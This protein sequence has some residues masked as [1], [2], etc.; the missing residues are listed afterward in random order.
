VKGKREQQRAEL[1]AAA[2]LAIDKAL[3][4]DERAGAP[5]LTE[6]EDVI[7]KLRKEFGQR[8][9]EVLLEGQEAKKPVPGPEC[10]TCQREM[11]YKGAKKTGV[12]T[13]LGTLGLERGYYYCNHC[14]MGIFPPRSTTGAVG[15]TLE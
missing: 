11:S 15:E 5:T 6:I 7:L 8:M 2:K 3:D 4:W 9:A 10:A 1:M 12:E 14:R 13:R